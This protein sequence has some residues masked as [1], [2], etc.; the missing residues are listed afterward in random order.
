[1]GHNR[2]T[3]VTLP[4]GA[5]WSVPADTLRTRRG[6]DFYPTLAQRAA[7]PALYGTE[8]IPTPE[9]VVHLHYFGGACMNWFVTELD[10]SCG[11][12]FGWAHIS[13]G[14]WGYFLL[15]E[16]ESISYGPGLVIER[17]LYWEPKPVR[18]VPQIARVA[19]F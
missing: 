17:D 12:A 14:E 5:E 9:K 10:P 16:L 8:D 18:E 6:H 13:D 7:I 2:P 3:P 1:M 19:R 11:L 15:P 4:N